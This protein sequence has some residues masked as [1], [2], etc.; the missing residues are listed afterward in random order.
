M[1][2]T[3]S[4]WSKTQCHAWTSAFHKRN[5]HPTSKRTAEGNKV[6]KAKGCTQRV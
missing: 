2:T 1:A 4:H 5:P 6:L 3:S